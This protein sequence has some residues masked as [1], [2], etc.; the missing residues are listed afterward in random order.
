ME[1]L[2]EEKDKEIH[3]FKTILSNTGNTMEATTIK[4]WMDKLLQI[5]T[6]IRDKDTQLLS[7]LNQ[8]EQTLTKL[9]E[10]QKE[11]TVHAT[12]LVTTRKELKKVN[13][14]ELCKH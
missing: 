9:L 5:K 4:Q 1:Q 14:S 13:H 7:A 3:N 12:Q 8:L 2:I 10:H 6:E 11:I